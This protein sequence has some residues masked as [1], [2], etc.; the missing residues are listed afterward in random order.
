MHMKNRIKRCYTS[1]IARKLQTKATIRYEYISIKMDK[2][3]KKLTMQIA[4]KDA[5]QQ[6]LL[7]ITDGK[8]K[9]YRHFGRP[10]ELLT[11]LNIV[12]TI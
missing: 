12:L 2:I 8:A 11:K 3:K 10:F 9:S 1:Y 6:N 4:G 5:E 7:F